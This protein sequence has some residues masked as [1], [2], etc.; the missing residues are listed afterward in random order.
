MNKLDKNIKTQVSQHLE[1]INRDGYVIIEDLIPAKIIS[2][3]STELERHFEKTPTGEGLFYG[4][5]TKRM[6]R[7]FSRSHISQDL[8]T[9]PIILGIMDGILGPFCQRY[10]IHLTQAIKIDPGE[11]QQILH[12]DDEM[13]PCPASDINLMANVMWALEDFTAQ[14]GA[15][16]VWPGSHKYPI[17]RDAPKEELVQ[18]VMK[19]GSALVWL[20]TT[21]HC[22][23]ANI[24]DAPR[25]G[26]TISYS[27][28]WLRQ[29]ENQFLAYPPEI[30][31]DFPSQIQ[32]LIGYKVHRPVLGYYEGQEPNILFEQRP[33]S[34]AAQDL[35]PEDVSE[36][37]KEHDA[38]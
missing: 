19:K 28:G 14:N 32:D 36:L 3:L 16:V 38:A 12:R 13:L 15:T 25:S 22:G 20:G 21:Q 24:S 8:A 34:L 17:T 10:Q 18:A 29:A 6:G 7:I 27:L 2:D 1:T 35:F 5:K 26:L 23:G 11:T 4:L 33:D 9:N 30:A 31:R 37:I